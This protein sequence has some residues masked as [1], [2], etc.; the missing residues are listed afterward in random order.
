MI[1]SGEV[2]ELR[3]HLIEMIDRLPFYLDRST[4]TSQFCRQLIQMQG[5]NSENVS[6]VTSHIIK[7]IRRKP[8]SYKKLIE[9]EERFNKDPDFCSVKSSL[10][11]VVGRA[12]EFLKDRGEIL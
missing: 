2:G 9:E 12:F 3:S 6:K 11:E 8:M 10:K 5:E 7:E 1:S 4:A